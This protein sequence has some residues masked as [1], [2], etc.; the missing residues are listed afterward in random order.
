MS[1]MAIN[2][3]AIQP[4]KGDF[5]YCDIHGPLWYAGLAVK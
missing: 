5:A 1:I 2:M 3:K 4:M